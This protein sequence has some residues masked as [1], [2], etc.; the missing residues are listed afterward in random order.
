MVIHDFDY[1]SNCA[2]VMRLSVDDEVADLRM[3][4]E[5]HDEQDRL[6]PP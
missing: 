5:I 6:W 1:L 4:P 3:Q 2:G